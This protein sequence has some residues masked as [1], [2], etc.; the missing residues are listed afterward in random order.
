MAAPAKG[1]TIPWNFAKWLIDADGKVAG[2]LKPTVS[3]MEF[4]GKIQSLTQ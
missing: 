2:Y 1:A 3:S 4:S